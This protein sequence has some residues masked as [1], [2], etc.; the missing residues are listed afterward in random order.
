MWR[1]RG[2]GSMA[3]CMRFGSIALSMKPGR[4]WVGLFLGTL[5]LLWCWAC[6]SPGD[7][8]AQPLAR[9]ARPPASPTDS[10]YD[11]R[12][13]LIPKP[14]IEPR[15][16]RARVVDVVLTVLHV[17]VP[18]DQ[19]ENV[20]GLW[21]HVREDVLDDATRERL[22][23]NGIRVGRGHAHWWDAVK[24]VLDAAD[25]VNSNA[26]DPVR[27]PAN[28]P[29]ALE[30]DDAPREQT[31]FFVGAD[32]VLTGQTWPRSRNVLRVRYRLDLEN[33]EQIR[34]EIVPEVRQQQDGWR[35]VQTDRGLTQVPNYSGRA[36][37]AVG[38]EIGVD[39]G[40]FVLIAPGKRADVYGMV[41]GAL[42]LQEQDDRQYD[43][44][45]F[46]RADVNHVAHR[47]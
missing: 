9:S 8:D 46:L 37:S 20:A 6:T 35:W 22:N 17:Q 45:V 1:V 4:E 3:A 2:P 25:G 24:A 15:A 36:F 10:P 13:E 30:L 38:F 39:P 12:L 21:N 28:Y 18:R 7:A 11:E 27:L 40:A 31:L 26:L 33:P 23:R 29:L 43:S 44:L 42:L 32:G 34:L 41:G 16:A 14:V 5:A 47:G 19:R